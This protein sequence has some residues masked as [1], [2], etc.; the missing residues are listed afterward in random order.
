MKDKRALIV[1]LGVSG[2][3]VARYLAANDIAFDVV[4]QKEATADTL[5]DPALKDAAYIGGGWTAEL[6]C[7]YRQVIVSPGISTRAEAFTQARAAGVDVVGDVELFARRVSK[8][9]VAVTGSN[10]KSTVVSMVGA[11]L[12]AAGLKAAVIGNVGVACLDGLS[13]DVD[14]YVLELSSFQLETTVSL[15]PHA[16]SVLNVCEDHLDR[17]T[18]LEDYAAVKRSIYRSAVHVVCNVDDQRTIPEAGQSSAT[19][20]ARDTHADWYSS[21]EFLCGPD[22]RVALDVLQVSGGHNRS[23]A[24]AAMALADTVV[25]LAADRKSDIFAHGLSQFNGLPHRSELVCA[26]NDIRWFNDSKGTNVGACVSALEGMDCPVVLIAGGRGKKADYAPMKSV[27]GRKCRAVVLIGEE[28]QNISTALDSV[29]P[30]YFEQSMADAVD[31]AGRI[32]E[33]GDCV[34]LS[35]ACSSFD[36]FENFEVRGLAFSAEVRKLCA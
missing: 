22:V 24:L 10:G 15:K 7:D 1:G 34:L 6:L 18:D 20:S 36:M 2:K 8:P 19:F 30:L 13:D 26:Q 3:S 27:V 4:D 17:Y 28:A 14:V 12:R 25:D 35:P 16:A 29:V 11:L 21:G 33:A 23:N 32:A 5:N 9:V 31:R